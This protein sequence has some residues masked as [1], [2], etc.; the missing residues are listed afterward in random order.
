MTEL[1]PDALVVGLGGNVGGDLAIRERFVRAREA[2]GQ[3]GPVRSAALYRTTPI[4][5][6]QEPFLNTAVRVRCADASAEEL[7]A[8]TSEIERLLGRNR[9]QEV[10]WGPRQIDLDILVW[11]MRV[12][13][14]PDLEV[15]H[16]RVAERRF[17][18]QPLIDLVGG[19]VYLPGTR[20]TL[21]MLER[22]VHAQGLTEVAPTW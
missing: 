21:A 15:P 7:L 10:R 17:A 3:L 8:T 6:A 22:R 13:R 18:L 16:P 9:A 20:S 11:G 4:G 19:D 12:A 14:T 2:L 1:P 5:P